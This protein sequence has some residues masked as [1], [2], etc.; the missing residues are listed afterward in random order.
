MITQQDLQYMMNER[1]QVCVSV[2]VP[3]H[4]TSPERLQ[5]K[6][7]IKKAI[8]QAHLLLEDCFPNFLQAPDKHTRKEMIEN[9][10]LL[11]SEIDYL[12]N[13]DG[14]GFFISPGVKRKI[15]FPFPV[16]EKIRVADTFEIR[17]TA[18]LLYRAK[19]Y[20]ILMLTETRLHLYQG[21]L[22]HLEEVKDV[23]F[24]AEYVNQFEFASSSHASSFGHGMQNPEKDKSAIEEL[25]LTEFL[26]GGDHALKPYL[27]N[28]TP[29]I[30][31]GTVKDI[32]Y[33]EKVSTHTG[34]IIASFQGNYT[35]ANL[36]E[37]SDKAGDAMNAYFQKEAVKY[38]DL[39][40][41]KVGEGLGVEGL[42]DVWKAAYEGKGQV[43]LLE[44]DYTSRGYV[45]PNEEYYL[46]LQRPPEGTGKVVP[47]VAN[48]ILDTVL[49][50]N[51]TVIF[52]ENGV[53]KDQGGIAMINR[54]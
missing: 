2:I 22:Q 3:T 28:G 5:D 39:Y 44:K 47:D 50:K 10:E 29:L 6:I 51:G 24:P 53:L 33:F 20:Y 43:L 23:F 21:N 46:H 37:L 32:A 35:H 4:R 49:Q 8:E 30:V 11:A 9:L 12:H 48:E 25:R 31:L 54:W 42:A 45:I 15:S 41:E 40:R 13:E 52:T 17:D 1:G 14:I 27:K 19:T 38:L 26:K 34:N 36:K 18:N 16:T 7:Q